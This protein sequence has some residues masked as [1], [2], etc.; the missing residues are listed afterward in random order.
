MRMLIA[1][2]GPYSA[3]TEEQRNMN[4]DAMND[5]AAEIYKKGHIPVIGINNALPIVDRIETIERYNSI[6]EISLE[7]IDRCDAILIIGESPGAIRERNIIMDKGL[8]AYKSIEE[9]PLP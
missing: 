8:P 3:E 9:I 1:V 7:I 5:A 2:A 6:M 4:L